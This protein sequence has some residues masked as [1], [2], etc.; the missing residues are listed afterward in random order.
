M[1]FGIERHFERFEAQVQVQVRFPEC[2]N[3]PNISAIFDLVQETRISSWQHFLCVK[4]VASLV[5]GELKRKLH[6]GIRAAVGLLHE[7]LAVFSEE[8]HLGVGVLIQTIKDINLGRYH[9]TSIFGC[10]LTHFKCSLY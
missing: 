2:S 9:F 5:V 6:K 10:V 3:S 1:H 8:E 7:V 4:K